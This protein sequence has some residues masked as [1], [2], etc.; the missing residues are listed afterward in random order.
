MQATHPSGKGV[1]GSVGWRVDAGALERQGVWLTRSSWP[2]GHG[3]AGKLA[4]DP[5]LRAMTHPCTAQMQRSSRLSGGACKSVLPTFPYL[6]R[7]NHMAPERITA[8]P[9]NKL[10]A[11]VTK[12]GHLEAASRVV[13]MLTVPAAMAN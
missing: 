3:T 1:C 11:T 13:T 5:V 12:G 7:T 6:V 10:D 4:N 2:V 9:K 8:A